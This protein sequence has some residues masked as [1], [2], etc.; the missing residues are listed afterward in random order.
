MW[1][2][3]RDIFK[4]EEEEKKRR[5]VELI[6]IGTFCILFSTCVNDSLSIGGAC[7]QSTSDSVIL[8]GQIWSH[9]YSYSE[10]NI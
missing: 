1:P 4:N 3:E 10:I 7:W 2:Q 8:F 9:T 6:F 5:F